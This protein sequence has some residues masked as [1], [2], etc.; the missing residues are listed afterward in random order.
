MHSESPAKPSWINKVQE[1]SWQAELL[2]SGAVIVAL[3]YAPSLVINWLEYFIYRADTFIAPFIGYFSLFIMTGV[4]ILII[5]L[6]IHFILRAW[7]IALLGL[8]F[9]FP[10]GVGD[11]PYMTVTKGILD[12]YKRD[13]TAPQDEIKR[14]D[15]IGSLMFSIILTYIMVYIMIA[16]WVLVVGILLRIIYSFF[17]AI[18]DYQNYILLGLYILIFIPMIK[19]YFRKKKY[20]DNPE[21]ADNKMYTS[22]QRQGKFLYLLFYQP[23]TYTMTLIFSNMEKNK[24]LGYGFLLIMIIG[25]ICGSIH[26]FGYSIIDTISDPEE[27]I[28]SMSSNTYIDDVHYRDKNQTAY[29]L[30][31]SIQSDIITEDYIKLFVPILAMDKESIRKKG[32]PTRVKRRAA[33]KD[34]LLNARLNGYKD[35]VTV[36][37][38][39]S[40]IPNAE[41]YRTKL[42]DTHAQGLMYYIPTEV[43]PKGKNEV[44]IMKKSTMRIAHNSRQ[45]YPL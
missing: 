27:M 22:M 36:T 45:L 44:S 32:Y 39:D 6:V 2:V 28:L 26:T 33:N 4:Y 11:K 43:L 23:V 1:E 30:Y 9:V 7:W 14:L 35:H 29:P 10:H 42:S 12:L 24:M 37:I 31:P 3:F 17:P 40:P 21:Y 20:K 34:S 38:N 5:L 13:F 18:V 8:D 15:K 16:F 19:S 25:N 41:I